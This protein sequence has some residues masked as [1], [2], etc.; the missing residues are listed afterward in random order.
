MIHSKQIKIISN[1]F[2][3]DGLQSARKRDLSRAVESL[4]KCLNLNKYHTDARN[5][6]GLIFYEMGEVSDALV[7]W[8]ISTNLDKSDGN[9]AVYYINLIQENQKH[10]E[11]AGDDIQKYNEALMQAQSGNFDLAVLQLN[12][13]VERQPHF[14]KA[15]LLLALLLIERHEFQRAGR[16]LDQ[17]LE[18]DRGNRR[19]EWYMTAIREETG[20]EEAEQRRIHHKFS[21]RTMTDDDVIIPP[22]YK[23]N[24]GWQMILNIVVGLLL[25][26]AA[27]YFLIMPARIKANTQQHNQELITYNEQLNQKNEEIAD[28]NSQIETYK[29]DKESAE[30]QLSTL[31]NDSG[32]IISQYNKLVLMENY[33]R[34]GD[35]ASAAAVYTDFNP[36]VF[37]DE[38]IKSIATSVQQEVATNGY[39][40]IEDQA[41]EEWNSGHYEQALSLY[42]TCLS[43]K[44]DNPKV[45]YYCAI[46]YRTMGNTDQAISLFTQVVTQYPDSEQAGAARTQL[47]ALSPEAAQA[48]ANQESAAESSSAAEETQG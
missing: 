47:S 17:V 12:G 5:L 8:V 1:S 48:A 15:K 44:P 14:V 41:Y 43:I 27:V 7:Q 9:R 2:Y 21:H 40:T 34:A 39:Q 26:A 18:I 38:T 33:L 32:S 45:I 16:I 13:V 25:G 31:Q 3:N 24:T 10:L 19:A 4:R 23:E 6:L 46:I 42:Q 37:T 22:S 29:A 35:I 36:E 20:R 11:A 30:Q 28:L